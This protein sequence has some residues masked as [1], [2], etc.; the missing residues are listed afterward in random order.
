MTQQSS[1]HYSAWIIMDF[2]NKWII[3]LITYIAKLISFQ[4]HDFPLGIKVAYLIKLLLSL[5]NI[6]SVY[7]RKG[8]GSGLDFPQLVVTQDCY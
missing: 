7:G 3:L 4:S 6:C 8:K 2:D 1:Q 5:K